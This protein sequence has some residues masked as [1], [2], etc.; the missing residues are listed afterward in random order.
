MPFTLGGT[1]VSGTD[2]SGVT[3]GS[4]VF[5]PGQTT[6][7]ITGTLLPDP[8]AYPNADRHAGHAQQQRRPRQPG[9]QHPDHHRTAGTGPDPDEHQ[10]DL[11]PGRQPEHDN[12]ADWEQLRPSLDGG[13]RWRGLRHHVPQRDAVDGRHSGFGPHHR[14][15]RHGHGRERWAG[16]RYVG[17]ANVHCQRGL[18]YGRRQ[19]LSLLQSCRPDGRPQRDGNERHR[20]R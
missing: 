19:C 20:T 13:L 1:A 7:Y 6:E 16:R 10:F 3:A 5:A 15:P 14:W 2:Y 18:R 8:G 17:P 11:S 4:L 9:L 12:F